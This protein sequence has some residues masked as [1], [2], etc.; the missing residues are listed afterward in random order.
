MQLIC[1][2]QGQE[3]Q[4]ALHLKNLEQIISTTVS[5]HDDVY[6][7]RLALNQVSAFLAWPG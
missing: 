3:M 4:D 7:K 1:S 5:T 6:I 2:L